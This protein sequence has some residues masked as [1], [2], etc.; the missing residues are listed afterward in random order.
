MP[1][2]SRLV[3]HCDDL[4]SEYRFLSWKGTSVGITIMQKNYSL[5]ARTSR[6]QKKVLELKKKIDSQSNKNDV[7]YYYM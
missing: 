7:F 2:L 4:K 1:S 6:T 5:R 3:V